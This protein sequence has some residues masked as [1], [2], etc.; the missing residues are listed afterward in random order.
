MYFH[1]SENY[2]C[3]NYRALEVDLEFN[4][5]DDYIGMGCHSPMKSHCLMP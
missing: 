5:E 1:C 2:L 3:F 4:R